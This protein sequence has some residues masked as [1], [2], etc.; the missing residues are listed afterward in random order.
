MAEVIG[1]KLGYYTWDDTVDIFYFFMGD[2]P[3]LKQYMFRGQV[4]EPLIDGWYLMDRVI[5][6]E[7]GLDGPMPN[8]PD[9]VPAMETVTD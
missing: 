3:P 8:P 6:G 4:W 5:D 7:P 2:E 9:G 1:S